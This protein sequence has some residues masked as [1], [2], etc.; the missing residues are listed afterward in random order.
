MSYV[1]SSVRFFSLRAPAEVVEPAHDISEEFP[2][3]D[4]ISL[5]MR[6][7]NTAFFS[8]LPLPVL[9]WVSILSNRVSSDLQLWDSNGITSCFVSQD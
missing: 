8:A 9:F 6:G 4:L 2:P 5:E 7:A 1:I 3:P